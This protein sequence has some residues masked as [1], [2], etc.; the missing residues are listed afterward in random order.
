[1]RTGVDDRRAEVAQLLDRPVGDVDAL[2]VGLGLGLPLIA[3]LADDL[4]VITDRDS[5]MTMR[6][7][8]PMHQRPDP[9]RAG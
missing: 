7:A 3:H 1:V 9:G 2:R 4:Q 6:F 5:T 8:L